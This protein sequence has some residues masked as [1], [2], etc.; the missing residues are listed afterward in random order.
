MAKRYHS[1]GRIATSFVSGLWLG[2]TSSLVPRPS[3]ARSSLAVRNNS[4]IR[5]GPFHNVMCS[6]AYVT[7]ILNDV[8]D[9]LEPSLALKEAPRDHS[10]GWCTN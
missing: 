10:N 9:E 8:I 6:A 3:R 1:P 5:P 2:K 4:L 7:T